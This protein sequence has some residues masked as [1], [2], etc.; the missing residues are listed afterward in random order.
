MVF[1]LQVGLKGESLSFHTSSGGSSVEW[2]EGSL[3]AQRQPLTWYKVN[4]LCKCQHYDT[5]FDH[6]KCTPSD[7]VCQF[8]DLN[9]I[10]QL[11][12]QRFSR[13]HLMHLKEMIQ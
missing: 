5:I 8:Y 6:I 7:M 12:Y 2:V 10:A 13:L 3:L 4:S 1:Y 11:I 9:K